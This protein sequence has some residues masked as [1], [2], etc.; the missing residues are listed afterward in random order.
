MIDRYLFETKVG[1]DY[2]NKKMLIRVYNALNEVMDKYTDTQRT[3]S[4]VVRKMFDMEGVTPNIR[5]NGY[6]TTIRRILKDIDVIRP[7]YINNK[8]VYW[9]T[10]GK[11]WDRFFS[12]EDWSWF[13]TDTNGGGS[14]RIVR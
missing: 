9:Y 14:G 5:I 7:A 4:N 11:N 1:Y 2:A 10:K 8:K 12:D 13:I 6:Y 3:W